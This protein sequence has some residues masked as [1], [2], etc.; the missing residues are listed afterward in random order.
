MQGPPSLSLIK[1]KSPFDRWKIYIVWNV[2]KTKV[3]APS[4][5]GSYFTRLRL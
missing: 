2:L 3:E 1:I 4:E 5:G